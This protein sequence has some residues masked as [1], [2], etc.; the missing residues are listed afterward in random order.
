MSV[1]ENPFTPTFGEIPPHLAG[2]RDILSD[3]TLAFEREGRSPDLTTIISGAR[4]TGKTALLALASEEAEKRGWVAVRVTAL[5]DMLEEILD[6]AA[7]RSEHLVSPAAGKHLTGIGLGSLLNLQ[8]EEHDQRHTWRTRLELLVKN[9]EELGSGLVILVDEVDP[10]LDE[11]LKLVATYQQLVGD[12]RR[13]GLIMAGIPYQVSS[14]LG[15]KSSSFLRRA[16]HRRLGRLLDADVAD[17]LAMTIRD[18]DRT[19][20][21]TALAVATEAVDGFAFMLQLVGYR[22]WNVDPSA[23]EITVEH[24]R[25][26]AERAR[27]EMSDRVLEATWRELS[28]GDIAFLRAMLPD[29]NDS[30][31]RDIAERMGKPSSYVSTYRRR[32]L[33]QGVIGERRR[34]VV[35]FEL[36]A[37]KEFLESKEG[38]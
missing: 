6:Q 2:R 32:L 31:I 11:L 28:D 27:A 19:I 20:A 3:L 25:I 15:N 22:V 35:G 29:K 23:R 1:P 26:G 21:D 10:K 5:P 14:L 13:I 12:R 8:W 36:P 17:A 18:S 38:T 4:G 34:G 7:I 33:E 30:A 16:Q 37:F 24:A 9:L